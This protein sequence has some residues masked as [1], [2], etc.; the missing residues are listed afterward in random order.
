[1]REGTRAKDAIGGKQSWD[2]F[3]SEESGS[4]DGHLTNSYTKNGL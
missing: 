4:K 1:M 3:Q 2:H